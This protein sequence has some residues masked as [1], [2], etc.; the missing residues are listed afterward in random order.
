[1]SFFQRNWGIPEPSD[2]ASWMIYLGG[3]SMC[4]ATSLIHEMWWPFFWNA[5]EWTIGFAVLYYLCGWFR[6]DSKGYR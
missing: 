6:R 4:V 5:G 2:L 1:M 3:I